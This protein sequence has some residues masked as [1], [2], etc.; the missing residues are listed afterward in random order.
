MKEFVVF[1]LLT[2]FKKQYPQPIN[3]KNSVP[4]QS[5]SQYSCYSKININKYL[6]K[7]IN[8]FH[9]Y[10]LFEVLIQF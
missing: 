9:C 8:A 4:N 6:S 3:K 5:F 2:A 10:L 1:Q 7:Q